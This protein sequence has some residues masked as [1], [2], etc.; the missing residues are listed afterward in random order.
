M[1]LTWIPKHIL[2]RLQ[3]LCNRYLWARN[4]DKCIFVWISWQKIA[5]Q[6]RWGGWGL[7]YLPLFAQALAAKMGWSLLTNQNLW[8][9]L[10]YHKY[11]WPQDMMDWVRLPSWQKTGTSSIWKALL[12]SLPLIRDNLVW[13]INNGSLARIGLDPWIGSG[14]RHILFQDHQI[15]SLPGDQGILTN[16]WPTELRDVYTG[17][18]VGSS[19]RSSS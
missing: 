17:M 4:Q 6:K 10:S 13:R 11:I 3:K 8:S 15:S 19:N 5:L 1:A 16:C 9:Y 12:H 2:S 14:G 7:K 18:E